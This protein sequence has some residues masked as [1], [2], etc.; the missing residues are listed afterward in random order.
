MDTDFDEIQHL[1]NKWSL[2]LEILAKLD[3]LVSGKVE[4]K[5]ISLLQ[6]EMRFAYTKLSTLQWN[7]STIIKHPGAYW[8]MIGSRLPGR[9]AGPILF[10]VITPI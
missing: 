8:V 6:N 5:T 2:D 9:G 3:I 10:V 4:T 1:L 7:M